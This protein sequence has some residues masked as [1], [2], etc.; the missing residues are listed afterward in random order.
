MRLS[1][2]SPRSMPAPTRSRA[3]DL[4]EAL[5]EVSNENAQGEYYLTD[6][7]GILVERGNDYNRSRRHR[8]R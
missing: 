4:I 5:G 8:Q 7:I 3:K 2:R 1:A 6:V